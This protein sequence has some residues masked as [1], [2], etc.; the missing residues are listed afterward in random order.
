MQNHD[1]D[2][3]DKANYK[4]G[5]IHLE[6]ASWEKARSFFDK[7]SIANR[8]KYKLEPL[9]KEIEKGIQIKTKNPR[10]AGCLSLLPGLGYAYLERYS[11]ALTAFL[12]NGGLIFGAFSAFEND[13]PALGAILAIIGSGFYGGNIFGAVS[14]AHK[15]NRNLTVQFIDRLRKNTKIDLMSHRNRPGIMLTLQ[16]RF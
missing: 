11:D 16:Y 13:N 1:P 7:V 3:K 10:W 8:D 4:I 15:H 2:V 9:Q 5:W 6:M 14:G 12:V